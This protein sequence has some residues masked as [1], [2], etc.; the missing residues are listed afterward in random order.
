M[1]Y[2]DFILEPVNVT[3]SFIIGMIIGGIVAKIMENPSYGLIGDLLLGAIGAVI[4]G[5]IV[6]FFVE[7][8]PVFWIAGLAAVIGALVVIVGGRIVVA[9]LS[10]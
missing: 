6:G 10:A 7:G 5:A 2:A 9:R 1:M 8:A 4:G 3:V